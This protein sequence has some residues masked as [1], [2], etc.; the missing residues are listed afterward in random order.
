MRPRSEKATKREKSIRLAMAAYAAGKYK[1]ILSA[2]KAYNIAESTLCQCIHG[3]KSVADGNV[4][5]QSLTPAEEN[6]LIKWIKQLTVTEYFPRHVIVQEL[7]EELRKKQIKKINNSDIEHVYYAPLGKQWVERF[8]ARHP[9]LQSL[10]PHSINSAR[11]KETS[12][13]I[14]VE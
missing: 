12:P 7:A 9:Q 14:I 11:I 13:E 5:C 1:S 8:I 2:A 3:G 6:I 4:N 10:Y